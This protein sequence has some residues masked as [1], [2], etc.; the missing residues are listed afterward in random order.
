MR[1]IARRS[2]VAA[3]DLPAGH[4]ISEGD[5]AYRRPG[6]GLMP[7]EKNQ[8]VGRKALLAIA[9]NEKIALDQLQ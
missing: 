8:V 4:I 7:Y 1:R 2:I 6:D 9:A 3:H 5:L